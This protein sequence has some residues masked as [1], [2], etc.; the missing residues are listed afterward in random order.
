[1][2]VWQFSLW[3]NSSRL[4]F[5]WY[6]CP[7][8]PWR[9]RNS[10]LCFWKFYHLL[11]RQRNYASKTER[12]NLISSKMLNLKNR[13][14]TQNPE[15]Q[16]PGLFFHKGQSPLKRS[17]KVPSFLRPF[18]FLLPRGFSAFLSSIWFWSKGPTN[19]STLA[20]PILTD[21]Q[22]L[23]WRTLTDCSPLFNSLP[24][25]G[26]TPQPSQPWA[27]IHLWPPEF[28]HQMWSTLD[29]MQSSMRSHSLLKTKRAADG[30]RAPK[31]IQF[32]LL[33]L[34]SPKNEIR[35]HPPCSP[36]GTGNHT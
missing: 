22:L 20:M 26:R 23:V 31:S 18:T 13:I 32:L 29:I 15:A 24:N 30:E 2:F 27:S 36:S 21:I 3:G 12:S 33:H 34:Q 28:W 35:S 4:R 9:R 11:L 19:K 6:A 8:Y 10:A 17:G 1:M 7:V 16:S 14:I 25:K 5:R